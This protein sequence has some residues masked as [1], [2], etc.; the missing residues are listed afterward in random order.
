MT[1][2]L[3]RHNL[4]TRLLAGL[5]LL[6]LLALTSRISYLLF[7]TLAEMFSVVVAGSVFAL[8]WNTRRFQD[9]HYLLFGGIAALFVAVIDMVHTMAYRGLGILP[10]TETNANYATQLWLAAR[11]LQSVSL[12]VAPVFLR[13]RLRIELALAG[14]TLITA[15]LLAA[16]FVWPVFPAAYV[17]GAGLTPFKLVS[18]F[19]ICIILLAAGGLLWANR[20]AF[21]PSVVRLLNGFIGLSILSELAFTRYIGVYDLS[22]LIGHLLK[23]AAFYLL[24]RAIVVTGLMQPYSLLFRSAAETEERYRTLFDEAPVMYVTARLEDG[25]P[26]ITDCNQAFARRLD[27]DRGEI[28][29]QPL[30]RFF[31]RQRP[32]L[33]VDEAESTEHECMLQARDG[34]TI[35]TLLRSSPDVDS[36]GSAQSLRIMFVDIGAL[37]RAEQAEREKRELAEQTN[38]IRLKFL[39]MV[40]HE[41]RAPLTSIRGFASTLLA[42]DVEWDAES[43]RD[44][45]EVINQES[46]KLNDLIDQ[47]LD[48][49][50]IQAGVLSIQPAPQPL[51]EVINESL[52][53]LHPLVNEHRLTV[54]PAAGL[55]PVLA[56]RDRIAQVLVNLVVNAS[57]FS[58]AGTEIRI[59]AVQHN[60][61]VQIDVADQGIGIPPEERPR[62][63]EAFRQIEGRPQSGPNKGAGLGL[64]I[65]KGLVEAHGG[66]I[67]IQDRPG[68]GTT[69]SFTLPVAGP[70]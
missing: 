34:Q 8:A 35:E 32:L 18:E 38:E 70:L 27:Y 11:Y 52:R 44:F 15:L 67:W 59:A 16:I 45:L 39:A 68:P 54:E 43:Q 46:E 42:P 23:I 56:D 65:C 7:H 60:A 62:I 2:S 48:L 33:L 58:P 55:P 69:I 37:K 50:R 63:F 25:V 51:D 17:E 5:V 61:A 57:K 26:V 4:L 49:S 13:R 20:R 10:G 14:F 30:H 22:N 41:L 40:S 28:V 21:D 36:S 24:Y 64:A 66:Q 31:A 6:S 3:S 12:L 47:L 19:L 9:H 1:A 29:G 53:V